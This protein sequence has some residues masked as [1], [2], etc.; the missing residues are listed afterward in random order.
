M[1]AVRPFQAVRY[2]PSV[3]GPV[4]AVLCPPYDVITPTQRLEYQ[5]RSPYNAVRL[6]LPEGPPDGDDSRYVTA[7]ATFRAWIEEGV[8][9]RDDAPAYYLHETTFTTPTGSQ[10]RRDVLAAV[11][12][13]PWSSGNVVP[14]EHTMAGPKADRLAL[15]R[16]THANLSPVWLL[17][18]EPVQAVERAWD[19]ALQTPPALEAT[20]ESERHRLWIVDDGALVALIEAGF[21]SGGPLYIADGHHR[22][23]TALGFRAEAEST[24][25]GARGALAVITWADDPGLVVLPT[26]RVLANLPAEVRLEGLRA[27]WSATFEVHEIDSTGDPA[28][29]ADRAVAS[30]EA[31]ADE[32]AFIVVGP[33]TPELTLL[34]AADPAKVLAALPADRSA[35]W[36]AL[37]LALLHAAVVDPLV[38]RAGR[39]KAEALAYLRDP[40]EAV[41]RVYDGSA[42][43]AFITHPTRVRQVLEVAD[44]GDRMPEKSTYFFPKPPTGLLV[45][46]LD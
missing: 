34:R 1:P 22:F 8:L 10:Q 35:A 46:P 31:H 38:A 36:R 26:H 23:E 19:A 3:A 6:E 16:A 27:A 28:R 17:H 30:L 41:E 5:A 42:A 45:R 14:H 11:D 39:D 37:D 15:L 43:A 20:Y 18:R 24:L 25:P 33:H 29:D 12:V 21:A 13:E 40:R 4:D 9:R 32:T 44:A 2:D 7:A